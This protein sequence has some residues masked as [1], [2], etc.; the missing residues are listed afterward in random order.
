MIT[1]GRA[2]CFTCPQKGVSAEEQ[3]SGK[4][5]ETGNPRDLAR[6]TVERGDKGEHLTGKARDV[7]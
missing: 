7:S 6:E 5:E 4:Q 2:F 1:R 3:C